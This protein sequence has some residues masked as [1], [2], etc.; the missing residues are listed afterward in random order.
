MNDAHLYQLFTSFM[1][2]FESHSSADDKIQAGT[3]QGSAQQ[4]QESMEVQG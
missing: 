3:S 4:P 2:S 1:K